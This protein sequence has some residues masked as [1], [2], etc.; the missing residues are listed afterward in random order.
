MTAYLGLQGSLA[1]KFFV[2]L[3]LLSTFFFLFPVTT[4]AAPPLDFGGKVT[5]ALPYACLN[6]GGYAIWVGVLGTPP[7]KGGTFF[8]APFSRL[9]S[10]TPPT[11]PGQQIAGFASPFYVPCIVNFFPTVIIGYGRVIIWYGTS[12][13]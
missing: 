11:H 6:L 9:V 3:L 8:V 5:F 13:I 7:I 1:V 10:Q 2:I 12:A 4:N